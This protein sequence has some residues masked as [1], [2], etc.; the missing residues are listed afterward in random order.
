MYTVW[1]AYLHFSE[2]TQG[3]I[4]AGKLADFTVTDRDFLTCPVDQIRAIEPVMT[5]VEGRIVWQRS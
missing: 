4:E 5:I 3:S 2:K 1:A